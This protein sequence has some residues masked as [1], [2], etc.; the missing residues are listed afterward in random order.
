MKEVNIIFEKTL[1]YWI[2]KIFFKFVSCGLIHHWG[3]PRYDYFY[4]L[5]KSRVFNLKKHLGNACWQ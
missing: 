2:G 1:S 4:Q 3:I 5:R